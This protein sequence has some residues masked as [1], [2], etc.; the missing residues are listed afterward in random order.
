MGAIQN[1]IHGIVMALKLQQEGIMNTC[2]HLKS[3]FLSMLSITVGTDLNDRKDGRN[4]PSG[5]T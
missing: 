4:P 5:R 1:L 2:M 3:G